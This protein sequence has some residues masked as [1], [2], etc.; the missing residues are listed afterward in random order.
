VVCASSDSATCAASATAWTNGW[1]VFEDCDG[2][3]DL[4]T[5][6]V[7]CADG[8]R[9]ETVVR[10]GQFSA[11]TTT[12]QNEPGSV[13][14]GYTPTGLP[15]ATGLLFSVCSSPMPKTG[16]RTIS[17]NAVGQTSVGHT[18]NSAACS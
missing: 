3:N 5:S 9:L 11:T 7:T 15:S 17:L 8:S 4:D 13:T 16:N 14:L 12:I 18:S 10:V 6:A 1:L 2:G